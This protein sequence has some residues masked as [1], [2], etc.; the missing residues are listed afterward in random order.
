MI[1]KF[2]LA[3][4]ATV[5]ALE[6]VNPLPERIYFPIEQ[7]Q[8]YGTNLITSGA[9]GTGWTTSGDADWTV[10]SNDVF[11]STMETAQAGAITDGQT[12]T[13]SWTGMCQYYNYTM[14]VDAAAGDEVVFK[15]DGVVTSTLAN[16]EHTESAL[17]NRLSAGYK[18]YTFSWEYTKDA[19]GASGVDTAYLKDFMC[20]KKVRYTSPDYEGSTSPPW[21]LQEP[22]IGPGY[23]TTKNNQY[24]YVNIYPTLIDL[25]DLN[26]TSSISRTTTSTT[27]AYPIGFYTT[28]QL[29]PFFPEPLPTNV[30]IMMKESWGTFSPNTFDDMGYPYSND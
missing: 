1:F 4:Q 14:I 22:Y 9:L 26:T 29:E 30:D 27:T 21:F 25:D 19:S 5:M 18:E 6:W 2:A 16:G 20:T 8:S 11:G 15:I 23:S 10:T 3:L 13:L 7:F 12:S 17:I 28:W 24:W